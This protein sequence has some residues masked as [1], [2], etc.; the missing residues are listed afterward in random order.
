M[1]PLTH[2]HNETRAAVDGR[3]ALLC[4]FDNNTGLDLDNAYIHICGHVRNSR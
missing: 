4:L 1:A 2:P 3:D